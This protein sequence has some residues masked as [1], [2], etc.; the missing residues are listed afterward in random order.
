MTMTPTAPPSQGAV[1]R[2]WAT[3]A[4]VQ[5]IDLAPIVWNDGVRDHLTTAGPACETVPPRTVLTD[6]DA[7]EQL[8]LDTMTMLATRTADTGAPTRAP[9][10]VA[11]TAQ[12]WRGGHENPMAAC[13]AD[14]CGWCV[15]AAT[16]P[17]SEGSGDMAILD[18]RAG[19]AMTAA[20]GLPWGRALAFRPQPGGLLVI[21]GWLTSSVRPL[22]RRQTII[23]VAAES[24]P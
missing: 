17:A 16:Q 1:T 8:F 24:R 6:T 15:L 7:L 14:Y 5:T 19:C 10:T 9:D 20:P 22:E 3:P 2:L 4:A 13:A 12:V 11:L 18:P 23:V 21:P